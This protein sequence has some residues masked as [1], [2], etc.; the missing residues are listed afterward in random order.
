VLQPPGLRQ[1]P[2]ARL[3]VL[4]GL[5]PFTGTSEIAT[6]II[7]SRWMLDRILCNSYVAT[8]DARR[9][10]NTITKLI[11]AR[12]M[13][14]PFLS[15]RS[16]DIRQ[17]LWSCRAQF[18]SHSNSKHLSVETQRWLSQ[19]QASGP[20]EKSSQIS[21]DSRLRVLAIS[22]IL[23]KDERMTTSRSSLVMRHSG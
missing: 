21:F 4:K 18:S 6:C 10:R 1:S 17:Q 7:A 19:A 5:S 20:R 16:A 23:L 11:N 22:N 14:S 8:F 3:H 12:L 2:N 15:G 13:G 9:Q